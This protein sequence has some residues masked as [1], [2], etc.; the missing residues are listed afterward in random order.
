MNDKPTI[1]DMVRSWIGIGVVIFGIVGVMALAITIMRTANA[2][3]KGKTAQ[4]LLTSVLPLVGT[5]VGTVL[6]YYFARENFES[7]ARNTK[8]LMGLDEKLR[9]VPV[10]TAMLPITQGDKRQ[11][12]SGED[13]ATLVLK[14]LVDQM[15]QAKR[16]RLP[17]LDDKGV[18]VFVIHLSSLTKFITEHSMTAGNAAVPNLTIG[19]LKSQHPEVYQWILSWACVKREATLADA[20]QAME[21]LPNCNDVF[22]TE[23]GSRN[24]PAIGWVTNAEIALRGKV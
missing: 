8:E 21:A 6:A 10:A 11:L 14:D 16:N 17:V 13:P 18:P 7:A 22:V 19:D 20:K 5:W 1:A 2:D 23:S 24:E 12:K 15:N 4:L 3:E 9:S